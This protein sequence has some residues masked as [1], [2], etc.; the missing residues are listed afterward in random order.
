[1][2]ALKLGN[3]IC[4]RLDILQDAISPTSNAFITCKES[5]SQEAG[6]YNVTEKV[7]VGYADNN[8]YMRRTSFDPNEY[9][10]FTALPAVSSISPVTGNIGGQYLTISGTGFSNSPTN[11]TV[12][13]DGNDCHVTAATNNE[14]KCTLAPKNSSLSSQLP[15][16]TTGTQTQGFFSGAGLAYARYIISSLIDTQDEFVAAVRAGNT[17][18]LGPAQKLGFRADVRES[19]IYTSYNEAQTWRGYFTAPVAGTYTF[20]GT[21]DDSFRVYLAANYGTKEEAATPLI[22]SNTV[23]TEFGFYKNEVASARASV[24]L[25]AGKSY[26]LEAF[27]LDTGGSTG[28]FHLAVEV[29]N[30]DSSANFQVYQVDNIVTD[31]TVQP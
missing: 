18:A 5:S 23:Q 3:D 2:Q 22:Y 25:E 9:F 31:S 4:S 15:T 10:E 14:L 24:D 29:P 7:I 30:V 6:K 17:A 28:F 11:N 19:N 27:H 21:A 12:T 16:N 8:R 13:V 20:R 26:Y 1:V